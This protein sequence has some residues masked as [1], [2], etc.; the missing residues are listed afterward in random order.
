MNF[1]L[2]R[3]TDYRFKEVSKYTKLVETI[4]VYDWLKA[5][6]YNPYGID[7]WV[8]TLRHGDFKRLVMDKF[9][10][11]VLRR[12]V[13]DLCFDAVYI[14]EVEISYTT[15]IDDQYKVVDFK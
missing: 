15:T 8:I 5:D 4:K 1:S 10:G 6:K 13:G 3:P 12:V 11:K 14:N 7:A 2:R 9:D